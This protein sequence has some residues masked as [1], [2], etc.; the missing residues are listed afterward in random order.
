MLVQQLCVAAGTGVWLQVPFNHP[1]ESNYKAVCPVA[2]QVTGKDAADFISSEGIQDNM[3]W[4]S[5]NS[6]IFSS[7][8][9]A[10]C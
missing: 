9:K 8:N 4:I 7:G 3:G 2:A 5:E 6:L 10:G 1:W